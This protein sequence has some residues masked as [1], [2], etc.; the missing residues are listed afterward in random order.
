MAAL[1]LRGGKAPPADPAPQG[2]VDEKAV[3]SALIRCRPMLSTL[4][5][6]TD[7]LRF[8]GVAPSFAEGGV[9]L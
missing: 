6:P 1:N 2:R 3:H 7:G 4:V 9:Y 8:D 5:N